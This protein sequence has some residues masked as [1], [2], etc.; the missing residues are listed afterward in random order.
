MKNWQ[1][2]RRRVRK[3]IWNDAL[4]PSLIDVILVLNWLASADLVRHD[5][6]LRRT[7]PKHVSETDLARPASPR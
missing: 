4:S 5:L 2:E 1:R 7:P 3:W 6:G